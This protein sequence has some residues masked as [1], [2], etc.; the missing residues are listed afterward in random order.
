[1]TKSIHYVKMSDGHEV[2]TVV[3]KP[4]KTPIGHIHILHG[5]AEHIGRYEQFAQFLVNK[6][7]VVTGHD[8][9]GHGFTGEKNNQKGFFAESDGFERVTEDVREILQ[10]V[11]SDLSC[12][13]PILFGHSMGSFIGR[14]F[15][16]KYGHSVSKIV[17]SG[18]GGPAGF[19]GKVGKFIASGFARVKGTQIE[20][21]LLN[22]MTFG[23]FNKAFTDAKTEFDWLSSDRAEVQK[24]INDPYCG[25][26]A[27]NQF[28]VDLITGLERVHASKEIANIP[29]NL[30][31][32]MISGTLDPVS[33][34]GK[35]LWSVAE[36][37]KKAGLTDIT[38]VLVEGKRHELLNE[39]NR[40]ETFEVITNWME[41]K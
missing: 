35:Q 11:R 2:Y 6:G 34:N 26:V 33:Q 40:E 4:Q 36:N 21:P 25:F 9:R 20:N 24:Y 5:M 30:P 17:L 22:K 1:M 29:K 19:S 12:D 8:H 7:Y 31:L 27:S 37:Y 32:L 3:Y 16:Q 18:T 38:V 15:I 23:K 39:V 13:L 41:K 28:F 10:D 14:R